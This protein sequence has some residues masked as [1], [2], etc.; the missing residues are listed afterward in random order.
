MEIRSVCVAGGGVMGLGILRGFAAQG[1]EC[2]LLSRDPETPKPGLPEGVRRIG[3]ADGPPPDLLIES[4]PEDLVLKQEFLARV[5][6]AWGGA[7]YIASNT[8]VLPLQVLADG[9]RFP[10]R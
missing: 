2:W 4:I 8:S 5:E 3:A 9:L 7:T 1:V 10:E 6:A